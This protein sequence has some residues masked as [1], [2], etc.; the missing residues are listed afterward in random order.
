MNNTQN[1][2]AGFAASGGSAAVECEKRQWWKVSD[3]P[4]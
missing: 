1:G 4:H 3:A 2:S